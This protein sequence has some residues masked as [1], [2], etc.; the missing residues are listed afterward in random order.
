[1]L[2]YVLAL[3]KITAAMNVGGGSNPE[4]LAASRCFPLFT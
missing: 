4:I 2:A 1:M 3:A